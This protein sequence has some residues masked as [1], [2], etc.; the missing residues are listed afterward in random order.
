MN[1]MANMNELWDDDFLRRLDGIAQSRSSEYQSAEP[2]PHIVIDEFFPSSVISQ[3]LDYFPNPRDVVWTQYKNDQEVKLEFSKV[4]R[5]PPP[6]RTAL[7]FCNTTPML[8]FLEK[9][10]GISDLIPDAYFVGGGL[11]QIE[12]GG[13]LEVHAD[14]NK[15]PQWNLDRRLNLLLYLNPEWKDEYG[16]HLELWNR[17][18]TKLVRKVLPVANRCVIFSTESDSYHGHPHPLNCP[19][20]W[21][22]KSIAL[23]YYT[24][25]RA[26]KHKLQAP[27]STLFQERPTPFRKVK[28]LLKAI[29]PP[30][31]TDSIRRIRG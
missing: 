26:D 24:N 2:F 31:V 7:Y 18:M 28:K 11:H 10:T 4:D 6:L 3:M 5:L 1:G 30:I 15:L 25:G 17:K 21:T 23:Y 29:L 27:H 12:R 22:R 9:L 13:K 20:G 14:F 19:D 8:Q 16:G